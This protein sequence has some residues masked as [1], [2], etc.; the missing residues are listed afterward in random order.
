MARRV[1]DRVSNSQVH[2][3]CFSHLRWSFVFQRPQ[4][5][6]SRA[7]REFKVWFFEEPVFFDGRPFL[8]IETQDC[9]VTVVT[10]WLPH[11]SST[12]QINASQQEMIVNLLSRVQPKRLVAWYYTPMALQFTDGLAPDCCVYD[13]MD[14]LSAFA[15]APNGI[16]VLEARLLAR[17]DVVYVGGHSLF[18]AKRNLHDNIHVFPS[19]VDFEHFSAARAA[20]EDPDDQ[21]GIP[22]PRLGFFGVIDERLNAEL[23]ANIARLRPE[24]QLVMIGPTAKVD[25]SALPRAQ[26]IHWLG[27]KDYATLP[28]YL[29][30]WDVAIMPF[31]IND[32]TRFI[33]PTKT[34]E[35]L[36]AG[37]PVVSTPIADVVRPYGLAGHVEIASDVASFVSC[38]EELLRRPRAPWLRSVDAHLAGMSWDETWNGMRRQ[39]DACS[40][41]RNLIAEARRV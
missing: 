2:L 11:G 9:G 36:A 41:N 28:N 24:W 17:C 21:R 35:F 37:V 20:L 15:G 3:F 4:H 14:E 31:A 30:G 19:S 38:A 16:A 33:S 22:R 1:E 12:E 23:V 8:K 18:E 25:A 39:L 27:C 6:M 13:N 26:N 34:P 32:A 10:P 40:A 5:L 7:A 29:A